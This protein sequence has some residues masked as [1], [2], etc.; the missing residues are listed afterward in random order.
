MR[1]FFDEN[2][3]IQLASHL[4]PS[5]KPD[6]NQSVLPILVGF[7]LPNIVTRCDKAAPGLGATNLLLLL[8][9]DSEFWSFKTNFQK[10]QHFQNYTLFPEV[11]LILQIKIH[12]QK[13][14]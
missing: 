11:Y 9:P 3:Q 5:R 8:L 13:L 6:R 12:F 7:G 4:E 1:K 14:T 10:S 2:I